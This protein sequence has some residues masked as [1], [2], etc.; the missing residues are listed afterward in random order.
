MGVLGAVIGHGDDPAFRRNRSITAGQHGSVRARSRQVVAA[1]TAAREEEE[2]Q[3]VPRIPFECLRDQR[4]RALRLVG[5]DSPA[6]RELRRARV[7]FGER[8]RAILEDLLPRSVVARIHRN[9][10]RPSRD[11]TTM[12]LC[13]TG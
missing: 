6:V 9:D 1:A 7:S 11:R 12:G 3:R 10:L 13:E 5:L 8:R 2:R 4:E